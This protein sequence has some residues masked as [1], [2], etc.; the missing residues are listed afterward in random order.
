MKAVQRK[1]QLPKHFFTKEKKIKREINLVFIFNR[2]KQKKHYTEN[3][4]KK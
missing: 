4:K 1:T 3:R 2:N